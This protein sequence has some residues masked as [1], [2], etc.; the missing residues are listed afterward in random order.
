MILL[1]LSTPIR[2]RRAEGQYVRYESYEFGIGVS[3]KLFKQKTK[4]IN[5]YLSAQKNDR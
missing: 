1:C 3:W 2:S 4:Y 5:D